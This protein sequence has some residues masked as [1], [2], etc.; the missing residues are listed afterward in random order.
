MNWGYKIFVAFLL[1]GLFLSVL[2]YRTFQSK[3]QLVA[4]DYYQQELEYQDQ[5]D[6]VN[7]EQSLTKSANIV[8]DRDQGKLLV[9]FPENHLV[10]EATVSLY[11]P[12]DATLDRS[13]KFSP[14][15]D[16][17]YGFD[18]NGYASGLWEVH[19]EWKEGTKSYLK[20]QNVFLK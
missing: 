8:L 19:L 1:F 15:G 18:I 4:P 2:I 13:W 20:R 17:T 5:I 16:G 11:R 3:V 6:K 10:T 14:D 9:E 7:N 12:S